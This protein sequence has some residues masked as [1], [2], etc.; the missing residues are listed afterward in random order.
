MVAFVVDVSKIEHTKAF[1]EAI[2]ELS[3]DGIIT[4]SP[5]GRIRTANKALRDIARAPGPGTR[6][7]FDWIHPEQYPE[8]RQW[9]ENILQKGHGTCPGHDTTIYAKNGRTFHVFLNHGFTHSRKTTRPAWS[10]I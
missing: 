2:I 5:E 10:S 3:A 4:A 7:V 1:Y 6:L 9:I 8:H